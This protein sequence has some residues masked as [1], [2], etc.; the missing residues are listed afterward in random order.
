MIFDNL[1]PQG[2]FK[3]NLKTMA[4]NVFGNRVRFDD[5]AAGGAGGDGAAGGA[6]GDGAAGGDG[7]GGDGKG[8]A[9]AAK[10]GEGWFSGLSEGLR[11][12]PSM[13][14]F[15]DKTAEDLGKSYIELQ[16]K[17]SSKGILLPKEGDEKDQSRFYGEI[18]RPEKPEGYTIS[19]VEDLHESVKITPESEVAFKSI[20]HKIGLTPAQMNGL[21]KWYLD[22]VS[23]QAKQETE[24]ITKETQTAEAKLRGEW[25]AGYEERKELAKKVAKKFGGDEL[26]AVLSE[27]GLDSHPVVMKAL[28][29][30]GASVSEDSIKN[31][32]ASDLTMTPELAIQE[33]KKIEDNPKHAYYNANDP[34]HKEARKQID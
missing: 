25:G 33:I 16:S 27:A 9:G 11:G 1:N 22:N 14:K 24:S 5:G 31:F 29:T 8:G 17:I 20:A 23:N 13:V 18:G 15:K 12:N 26:T 6:G 4:K 34:L 2:Q 21:N 7:K 3:P 28:A 30:I 19:K 10:G 32:G